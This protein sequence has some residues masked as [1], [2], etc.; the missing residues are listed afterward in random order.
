MADLIREQDRLTAVESRRQ[1]IGSASEEETQALL[2][3]ILTQKE[4]LLQEIELL[5]KANAELM[6]SC[7]AAGRK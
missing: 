3:Q 6:S 5:R 2:D 1:A 7:S 4:L